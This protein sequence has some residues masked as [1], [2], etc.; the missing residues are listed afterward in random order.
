MRSYE[1]RAL[2]NAYAD[3]E[4]RRGWLVGHFLAELDPRHSASVEVKWGVHGAGEK[5]Q[6]SKREEQRTTLLVLIRGKFTLTLDDEA[7]VLSREGDYALWGPGT[8]HSWEANADAVVITVRWP[9][10]S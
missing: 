9:S 1:I 4:A 7:H 8:A 6:A 3:G 10:V 2:G 5:R